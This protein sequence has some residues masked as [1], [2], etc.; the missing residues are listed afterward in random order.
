MLQIEAGIF[1]FANRGETGEIGAAE[2]GIMSRQ[3]S[4][5]PPLVTVRSDSTVLNCRAVEMLPP[6]GFCYVLAIRRGNKLLLK[7]FECPGLIGIGRLSRFLD[8][9]AALRLN[10]GVLEN[11]HMTPRCWPAVLK[12]RG[13]WTMS[14]ARC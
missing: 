3:R 1:V 9:R 2:G 5:T 11:T 7:P 10:L 13:T 6:A 14:W 8:G 4:S 12:T